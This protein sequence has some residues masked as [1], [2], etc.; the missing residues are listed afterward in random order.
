M[1]Q[2]YIRVVGGQPGGGGAPEAGGC[3]DIGLV[4]GGQFAAAAAGECE[5]Y[6]QHPFNFRLGVAHCVDADDALGGFGAALGQGVVEPAGQLAHHD[7]I[8]PFQDLGFQ[9]AGIRELGVHLDRA[10]VGED[11]EM[12]P[13]GQE[14]V[15]GAGGGRRV[16]PFGAAD[17]AEQDR[18]RR[19]GQVADGI[20]QG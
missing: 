3:E 12:G 4:H 18:V 16:V 15:L 17:G 7:Q 19:R 13:Q 10:D 6:A 2:G 11:I 1:F 14:A 5:A 9:Y 20:G 8:D